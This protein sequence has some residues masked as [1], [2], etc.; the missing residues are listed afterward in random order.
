ML[1]DTVIQDSLVKTSHE[2][3][4]GTDEDG[5][6]PDQNVKKYDNTGN[7]EGDECLR[8]AGDSIDLEVEEAIA[9]LPVLSPWDRHAENDCWKYVLD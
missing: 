7:K 4:P 6:Y 2:H 1:H 8:K 5:E 3:W 9:N